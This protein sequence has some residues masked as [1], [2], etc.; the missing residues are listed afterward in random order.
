MDLS[1]LS[2]EELNDLIV[3]AE[4]E[5]ESRKRREIEELRAQI[6]SKAKL[7]GISPEEL[8]NTSAPRK[9]AGVVP[10]KYRNPQN[11]ETWTGRG[12]KPLW[13]QAWLDSGRSLDEI[14]V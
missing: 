1:N 9:K 13:V 7:L 10:A 6:T 2:I 4:A 3:R 5:L 11:G 8:L 12:R 14:A